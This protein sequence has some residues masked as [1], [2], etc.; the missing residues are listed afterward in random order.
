ML[1][2]GSLLELFLNLGDARNPCTIP[3]LDENGRINRKGQMVNRNRDQ[4]NIILTN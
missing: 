4:L 3:T 2:S 1:M